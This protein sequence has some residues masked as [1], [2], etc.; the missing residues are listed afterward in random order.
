[1]SWKKHKRLP[2]WGWLLC[3]FQQPQSAEL[4]WLQ[5]FGHHDLETTTLSWQETVYCHALDKDFTKIWYWLVMP[6]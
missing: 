3:L 4:L 1:M 2:I 6:G 5:S